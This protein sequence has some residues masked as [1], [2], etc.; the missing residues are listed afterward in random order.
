FYSRL[1]QLRLAEPALSTAAPCRILRSSAGQSVLVFLREAGGRNVLVLL[2][3]SARVQE[4]QLQEDLPGPIWVDLFNGM[5]R[6][7]AEGPW[8]LAPWGYHVLLTH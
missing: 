2:N 6:D 4:V 7:G 1:L 3:L 8:L 5:E